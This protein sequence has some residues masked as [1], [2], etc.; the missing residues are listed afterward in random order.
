M[1]YLRS[2][3]RFFLQLSSP[4]V[5]GLVHALTP[6]AVIEEGIFGDLPIPVLIVVVLGGLAGGLIHL[7]RTLSGC[8][9]MKSNWAGRVLVY[10]VLVLVVA[11]VLGMQEVRDCEWL[12]CGT[13]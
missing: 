4:L 5:A 1:P 12:R 13:S 9:S 7:G 3:S 11:Q 6:A 10:D 8:P 2:D